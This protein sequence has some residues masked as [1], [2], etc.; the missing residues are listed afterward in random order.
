MTETEPR[1]PVASSGARRLPTTGAGYQI[2]ADPAVFASTAAAVLARRIVALSDQERVAIALSGGSTPKPVYRALAEHAEIEWH[3]VEVFFA[4]ERLVPFDDPASN[5]G[6]ARSSLLDRIPVP[7]AQVHPL[8]AEASD[9]DAALEAYAARMPDRL[10]IIVLGV[11]TD[12]HTASLFPRSAALRAT[13]PL[14]RSRAPEAPHERITVTPPVIQSAR[15]LLVLAT[16]PEKSAPVRA[17][18]AE[19]GDVEEC[20]ARLARRGIW[21]L[22]RDVVADWRSDDARPRG[23]PA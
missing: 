20:P 1:R 5:F 21:I 23:T 8:P 19:S 14:T 4:D 7:K 17:A 11:G 10:D 13:A 15:L 3:R 6:M 22:G 16:G 18:T 12:G 2:V 9:L